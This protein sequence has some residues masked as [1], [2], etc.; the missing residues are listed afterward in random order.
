M[1][2]DAALP[3]VVVFGIITV[4][5]VR[6]RDVR[7]WEALLIGL[8]GVYLGQTPVIFTVNGLMTWFLSGFTHT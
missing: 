5:L 4:L 1:S 3:L 8:F 6:S 2:E 7:W